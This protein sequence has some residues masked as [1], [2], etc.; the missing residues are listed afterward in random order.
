MKKIGIYIHIPFC[1]KRC[2][3]CN[4]LSCTQSS[5]SVH[6]AYFDAVRRELAYNKS[7][8]LFDGSTADSVYLGGG[9]P[10]AVM[11][12]YITDTLQAVRDIVGI[13]KDAE[14]SM[15]A[16]PETLIMRDAAQYTAAGINRFSLGLQSSN[17]KL[18]K[19]LGREHGRDSFTAALSILR[20][21]GVE[22]IS[23][24][25]LLGIPGQTAC[26]VEADAEFLRLS[27]VKHVSAYGLKAEE[28]TLL[29][30]MIDRKKAAMPD[31]DT[32]AD[33]Y[34]LMRQSLQRHGINRYEVSNFC[35]EGFECR[36]NLKYWRVLP[37]IGLGASAHSCTGGRRYSNVSDINIYSNTH[38]DGFA[39]IRDYVD[40]DSEDA[41]FEYIMLGLRLVKGISL[42][43][44]FHK[45]GTD[46]LS[47]YDAV[48]QKYANFFEVKGGSIALA[49]AGFY[50]QNT[51][52]AEF[53]PVKSV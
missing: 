21:A 19:F 30:D 13:E 26:D 25:L 24:D 9:T 52:L 3:Y 16:N 11:P 45:F 42:K 4:F 29:Y 37:Y 40:I 35:A 34:D 48:L 38:G 8:G 1:T 14:I 12:H 43:D 50:V 10:T 33:Y 7:I 47:K 27:A 44:F 39:S 32:C 49:D 18:L 28:G 22:N 23:A 31:E 51:I 41:E 46:F 36:H 53:L 15:E 2:I 6:S 20:A 5:G 17:E